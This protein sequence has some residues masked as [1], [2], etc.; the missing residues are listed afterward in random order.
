MGMAAFRVNE[1]ERLGKEE[2]AVD[3]AAE[4]TEPKPEAEAPKATTVTARKTTS[5]G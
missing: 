2:K 4:S 5:K 3:Q 1:E